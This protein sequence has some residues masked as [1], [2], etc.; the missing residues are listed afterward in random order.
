MRL[1]SAGIKPVKPNSKTKTCMVIITQTVNE[2]E[3]KKY[4]MHAFF[5]GPG[6]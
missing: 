1:I 3:N 6:P 2:N 4:T 5:V